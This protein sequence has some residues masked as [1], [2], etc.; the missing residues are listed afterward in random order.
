MAQVIKTDR[1]GDRAWGL[2]KEKHKYR[3]SP[4]IKYFFSFF[5]N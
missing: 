2:G 1:S 5:E 3:Q 4:T